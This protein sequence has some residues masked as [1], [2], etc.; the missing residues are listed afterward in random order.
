MS[1]VRMSDLYAYIHKVLREDKVIRELM[2]FTSSTT[3][4]EMAERIQKKRKPTGLVKPNL[5]IIS[6]YVNPGVR[7]ENHLTYMTAFDFDIYVLDGNEETA[8]DLADRINA[9]FD[10]QYIGLRCVNSLKCEFLTM[11]EDV[12]DQPD[13]YKF[14]TQILFTIG[15]EG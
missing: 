1:L 11:G 10:G 7:G 12:T 5:P 15:L 13:I 14:F 2:G 4:K 9:L 8:I 3:L 6:F